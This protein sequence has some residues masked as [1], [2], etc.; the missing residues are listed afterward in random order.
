VSGRAT[1]GSRIASP[2]VLV[3][4]ILGLPLVALSLPS[5]AVPPTQA[6]S[7]PNGD[8]GSA[9]PLPGP[10]CFVVGTG[11]ITPIGDEDYWSFPGAAGETVWAY[12]DTGG[13]QNPDGDSRHAGLRIFHPNGTGTIERDIGDGTGNGGDS[14][15]ETELSPTVAGAV[16]STSGT[17][18]V[19]PVEAGDNAVVDPYRLFLA[20]AS[21]TTA[22][23][24]P[25]DT[26][27][28]ATPITRCPDVRSGSIFSG[29]D[30][31]LYAV[32]VAPNEV[33]FVA[34]DG[35][36]ERDG[37]GPDLVMDLLAPNGS[38][39]LLTADSSGVTVPGNPAQEGDPAAEAFSFNIAEGGIYFVQV[40]PAD[41]AQTGTYRLMV[42]GG[43]AAGGETKDQCAGRPATHLGTPGDDVLVG[44]GANETFVGLGGNDKITGGGGNDTMCGG[45]GKDTARGKSGKDRIFGEGG[46]D[47]L[48]GGGGK[49]TLKG[50]P[51]KDRLA[52]QGGNDNLRGQGGS[53][54]LNGGPGTDRCAQG[55]GSGPEVSCE[56]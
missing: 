2:F 16:L 33:V 23:Q 28:Q 55:A 18:F 54:R 6:E 3:G 9:D 5:G 50:G 19:R 40:R 46:G 32:S 31:D 1:A 47:V 25:D 14:T 17:H 10:A 53:D 51:G 7:E 45:P 35:D 38:D 42:A 22:T 37:S 13:M 15:I 30:T 4:L 29:T 48:K 24:E 41:P 36:P 49:D 27:A 11:A 12:V 26:T 44:T 21:L 43:I 34:L 52:G 8:P 20:T 56:R 39:T